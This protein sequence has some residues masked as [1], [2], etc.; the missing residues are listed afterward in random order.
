MSKWL[1]VLIGILVIMLAGYSL[2]AGG[3]SEEPVDLLDL[4][5]TAVRESIDELGVPETL[6]ERFSYAF[7]IIAGQSFMQQGIELDP[8]YFAKGMSDVYAGD[9]FLL[10]FEDIDKALD[11]YQMMLME[12]QQEF[13]RAIAAM[14]L[15]TAESFLEENLLRDTVMETA[16]GL[17]YEIIQEGEGNSPTADDVV[18][19]HYEGTFIDGMVFDSSYFRGEPATFPLSGVIPGWTEGV[20]LMRVGSIYK[21]YLHPDLAYGVMGSPPHIEPNELLIFEVELIGIE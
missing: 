7:G 6:L 10:S 4:E 15:E 2:F 11:E 13:E 21:F 9:E 14:N 18:T 20:Q 12:E 16:S 8:A 1:K 19:V 3:Q 5:S 17:Q